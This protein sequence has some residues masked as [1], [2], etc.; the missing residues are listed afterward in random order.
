MGFA[1]GRAHDMNVVARDHLGWVPSKQT[2]FYS[3][4]ALVRDV[5]ALNEGPHDDGKVLM[6]KAHCDF[7]K[8]INPKTSSITGG[9]IFVS[10]RA[11]D[12]KANFGV[13]AASSGLYSADKPH[14]PVVLADRVHVHFQPRGAPR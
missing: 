4:G 12:D 2:A 8:S 14:M 10:F 7:C 3:S 5:R 13:S 6:M 11:R 9:E 1:R